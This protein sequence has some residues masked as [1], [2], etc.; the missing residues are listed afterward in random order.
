VWRRRGYTLLASYTWSKLLEA[1]SFLNES[2]TAFERRL[3]EADIPHHLVVSGIW[4]LPFGRGRK[5]GSNWNRVIDVVAGG[6]QFQGIGQLQT[7]RPLTIGQISSNPIL[8]Y[9]NFYYNADFHG[10]KSINFLGLQPPHGYW[11]TTGRFCNQ[12]IF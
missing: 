9:G 4:E 7:G 1:A 5:F 3:S 12:G 6:W 11:K 10:G 8:T 2:D